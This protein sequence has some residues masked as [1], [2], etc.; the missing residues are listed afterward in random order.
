MYSIST[1]ET[2]NVPRVR[3]HWISTS[4][5]ERLSS[6]SQ[7]LLFVSAV[8]LLVLTSGTAALGAAYDGNCDS[9]EVCVY[10]TAGYSAPYSDLPANY[11]DMSGWPAIH[12]YNVPDVC[13]SPLALTYPLVTWCQL[14]DTISSVKNLSYSRDLRIYTNA[15]YT[16]SSQFIGT[17]T[18][19]SQVTYNDQT[20]SLKWF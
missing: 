4:R 16:G 2:A 10:N 19:V 5:Q 15:N 11:P 6:L 9:D 8:T 18:F 3:S 7:V 1:L 17:R 20:S 13:N 12:T 14:N